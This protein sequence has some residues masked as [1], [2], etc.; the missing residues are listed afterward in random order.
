MTRMSD[1]QTAVR[2]Q[3]AA[4]GIGSQT[5]AKSATPARSVSENPRTMRLVDG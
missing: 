2:V 4:F 5:V 3:P 1:A